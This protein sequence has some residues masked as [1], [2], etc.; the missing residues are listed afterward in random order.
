MTAPAP[1][2]MSSLQTRDLAAPPVPLET[3]TFGEVDGHAIVRVETT[4]VVE[5]P[6]DV[7]QVLQCVERRRLFAASNEGSLGTPVSA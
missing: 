7:V 4:F 6:E 3:V 2:P 5:S 1:T